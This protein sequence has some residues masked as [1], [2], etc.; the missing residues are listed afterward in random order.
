METKPDK[1][2]IVDRVFEFL[3]LGIPDE[4]YARVVGDL[5]MFKIMFKQKLLKQNHRLQ[6]LVFINKLHTCFC[7]Y[8]LC[9]Y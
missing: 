2:G 5:D 1:K 9:E 4:D 8:H 3:G 6:P 7:Y